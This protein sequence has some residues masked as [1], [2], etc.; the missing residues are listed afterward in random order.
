[1]GVFE[2][3]PRGGGAIAEIHQP[4]LT[5]K[6]ETALMATLAMM[7]FFFSEKSYHVT[8]ILHLVCT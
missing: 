5:Q 3:V 4:S 2:L 1:M 6:L 7:S 8:V